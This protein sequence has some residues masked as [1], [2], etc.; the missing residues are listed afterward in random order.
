MSKTKVDPYLGS[1]PKCGGNDGF[2]NAGSSHIFF[3]R[4]H[5]MSWMFGANIFNGWHEETE[6]EQRE[7]YKKG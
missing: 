6:A 2:V 4:E 5:K 3:C 7:N 1:Y